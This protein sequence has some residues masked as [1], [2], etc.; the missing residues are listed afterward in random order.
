[1]K[2]E[3]KKETKDYFTYQTEDKVLEYLNEEGE[4][5]W[6]LVKQE[7]EDEVRKTFWFKR[8]VED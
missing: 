2:W 6:E 1:M 8:K 3:Y 7:E 5:G 4:N